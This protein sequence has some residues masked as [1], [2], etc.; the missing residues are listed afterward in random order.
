VTEGLAGAWGL[1]PGHGQLRLGA[2]WERGVLG[3]GAQYA[4]RLSRHW[5]TY[6]EGAAVYTGTLGWSAQA[7]LEARW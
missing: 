6:A 3:A 1:A 5:A 4:H 7:G 2:T